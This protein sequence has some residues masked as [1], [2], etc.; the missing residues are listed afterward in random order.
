MKKASELLVKSKAEVDHDHFKLANIGYKPVQTSGGIAYGHP[1][2][3][4]TIAY[5]PQGGA[6]P[7]HVISSHGGWVGSYS[8]PEEAHQAASTAGGVNPKYVTV[9]T[10]GAPSYAPSSSQEGVKLSKRPRW[11]GR[12]K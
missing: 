6:A 7:Y 4:H 9:S 8:N 1:R 5:R 12:I 11:S 2:H 10:T 3:N